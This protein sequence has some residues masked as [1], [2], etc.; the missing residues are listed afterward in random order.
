VVLA[1][2]AVAN[3]RAVPDDVQRAFE[4][5]PEV[6]TRADALG[7][8]LDRLVLDMVEAVVMQG[9]EGTTFEAM[10]TDIDDRGARIQLVDV[11]VVARVDARGVGPGERVRVKLIEASP[12]DRSVRFE[13]VA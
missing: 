6:M 13:R 8:R 2:L 5:L 1:S 10:I 3:G 4:E 11:P 12:A 7:N 9:R